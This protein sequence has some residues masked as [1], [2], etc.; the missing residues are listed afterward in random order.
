VAEIILLVIREDTARAV[1]RHNSLLTMYRR[2]R[3]PCASAMSARA[4]GTSESA[5]DR[6]ASPRREKRGTTRAGG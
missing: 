4:A 6:P 5:P 2:N 3:Q 1:N